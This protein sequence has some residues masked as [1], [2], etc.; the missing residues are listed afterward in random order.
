[1]TERIQSPSVGGRSLVVDFS[2]QADRFGHVIQ[3]LD[4]NL[5]APLLES[6]E[7]TPSDLWP[8]SPVLQ[9]LHLE[10][11]AISAAG[12]VPRVGET[13]RRVGL[14]VG[15]A[16]RSHWSLSVEPDRVSAALEFDVAC[17]VSPDASPE[18]HSTYRQ[19]AGLGSLSDSQCVFPLNESWLLTVSTKEIIPSQLQRGEF[20]L[21][22]GP[23]PAVGAT[24]RWSY[25]VE[26]TPR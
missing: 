12:G 14:L 22:I 15:M 5:A 17:K 21:R 23:S 2:R 10:T 7:G 19:L 24:R 13:E 6:V 9:H 11:R 16:G 20:G 25:R 26:L 3:W 8:N 1:M 4:G 18:L